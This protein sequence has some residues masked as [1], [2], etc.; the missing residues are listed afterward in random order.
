[1]P[2]PTVQQ[3]TDL[4][5]V[6]TVLR[7]RLMDLGM[8]QNLN[9]SGNTLTLQ[10]INYTTNTTNRIMLQPADEGI[11]IL[12]LLIEITTKKLGANTAEFE[13]LGIMPND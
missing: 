1:M 13:R 2:A 10:Q 11:P 12:N 6:R 7:A 5:L 8:L 3:I 9:A 4:Q